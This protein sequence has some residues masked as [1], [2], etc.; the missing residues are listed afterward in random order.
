MRTA[1]TR[2]GLGRLFAL[3]ALILIGLAPAQKA[4]AHASLISTQPEDGAVL[5]EAPERFILIF[6]EPVAPLRLQLIDRHGQ[7]TP[8][9]DIVQHNM[10]VI[11]RPP[12]GLLDQGTHALSWRVVSSDGHP[13][14]GT[15]I[16]SVGQPDATTPIREAKPDALLNTTIWLA[17]IAI[18]VALFLGLGGAVF[19]NWLAPKRPLPGRTEKLFA[20]LCAAGLLLVPLSVGLQGLDALELPLSAIGQAYA[21][22]TGFSTSYGSSALLA[23]LA[24]AAAW[25]SLLLRAAAPMLALAALVAAGCALA[26]S[27]HAATASPQWL[28]RPSVWLHAVAVTL[29]IG[30]LW[31]VAALLRGDATSAGTALRRF[32]RMIPWVLVALLASGTILA[33]VQVA[34][35]QA[36]WTTNYGLILSMKL[37]AVLA[38][39][40]RAAV[41]RLLLTREVE[42][43][44][45][46]AR[47]RLRRSITA[48]IGLALLIFALAAG[49]RFTPPPRSI[50]EE[51]QSEFVHFHSGSVMADLTLTPGRR[52]RSEG[53]IMIRDGN[54]QPITPKGVT[55]VFSQPASGIE[56]LRR[57]AAAI[58][59][60]RWRLDDIVLP[61]A[62]RWR[63]QIEVLIDDF[64]KVSLEDDILIRP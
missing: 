29:W 28:M 23:F 49:W 6:N 51:A 59:D 63:L 11:V 58:G 26:A 64:D 52:G 34:R 38:M 15:L 24:L 35:L 40:A 56:P 47:R 55:L 9:T 7:A 12:P 27:G 4:L 8:L 44:D 41:N 16:F 53:E 5:R 60:A 22:Q 19:A 36:L 50:V 10:T 14:G 61:T 43:G 46:A 18:F 45:M 17:R 42:A 2:L 48:E 25:V 31:P 62:G 39:L 20:V 1:K 30:S 54:F 3:A 21:W 57:E 13:V 32:T 33:V 37:G